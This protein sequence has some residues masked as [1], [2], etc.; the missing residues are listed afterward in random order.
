MTTTSPVNPYDMMDVHID[1]PASV[2]YG[3][4]LRLNVADCLRSLLPDLV[5]DPRVDDLHATLMRGEDIPAALQHELRIRI[6]Y[7]DPDTLAARHAPLTTDA[8]DRA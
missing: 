5:D 1:R 7:V 3:V 4:M 8:Q 6:A 2:Q